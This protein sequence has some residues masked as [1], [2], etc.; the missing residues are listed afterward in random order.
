MTE[1]IETEKIEMSE[2]SLLKRCEP[3]AQRLTC[4]CWRKCSTV[5][6]SSSGRSQSGVVPISRSTTSTRNCTRSLAR[7]VSSW[8]SVSARRTHATYAPMLMDVHVKV[9]TPGSRA[10]STRATC[11]SI[12]GS[13]TA[14]I[15]A[16]TRTF[17]RSIS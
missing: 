16:R 17:S 11:A 4:V 12:S 14:G 8:S 2:T 10:S 13:N 1:T 3:I 6:G 9:V 7:S 5:Q 15:L